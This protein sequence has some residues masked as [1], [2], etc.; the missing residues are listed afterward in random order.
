MEVLINGVKFNALIDT[1]AA[2]SL[3]AGNVWQRWAAAGIKIDPT[4]ITLKTV[5]G[6]DLPT[7]GQVRIDVHPFGLTDLCVTDEITADV[8]LG[9]DTLRRCHVDVLYGEEML[10]VHGKQYPFQETRKFC[11]G[12]TLVAAAFPVETTPDYLSGIEDHPVFEDRLGHCI[13]TEPVRINTEG[14]PIKQRAYRINLLKRRTVDEEIEK[15]LAQGVIRPSQSPWA[16]PITLVPKKDGSTRMCVDYRRINSVTAKDAY[17]VPLIQEIF[18]NLQGSQVFTTLDLR[19]GY[20]QVDVHPDDRQKTAFTCHRGLFEYNRLPFGLTNAPS[21]FQRIMNRILQSHL[22]RRAMVYID[23]VIIYSKTPED[24]ARDVDAVLNT[25]S[26]AGLTFKLKKCHFGQRKVEL[27]GYTVSGD[28]ISQQEDK[29]QAIRGMAAPSD[30]K[31]VQRF[32]GLTGYYR[33]TIPGYAEKAAPLVAL[34]RKGALFQWGQDEQHAFA[35]LKD[36]LTSERIMAHPKSDQAYKLY[37]DASNFAVGAILAQTDADGVE[38][39]VHY[40]SKQLTIGQ[41]KW[42]AIEREAFAIIYAL[43]KLRPYLQGAVFTVYTDHKPLMSLFQCE[44]KNTRVQRWAMLISEFGPK[45]EY[46]SGVN[47]ARADMLSRLPAAIEVAS[48]QTVLHTANSGKEQQRIYPDQWTMAETSDELDQ[49]EAEYVLLG[50]ELY[51]LLLPYQ[52]ASP[53]PRLLVPPSLQPDLLRKG[54]E[55]TG[56]RGQFSLLR[57]LQAFT[58]W[59]GMRNDVQRYIASCPHCAGNRRNPLKTKPCITETPSRPFERIG[60]DL[61]GPFLPSFKGNKYLMNVVDHLT[62]WAESYPIRDKKATTVWQTLL[63]EFFPRHGHP[64]ILITDQGTEFNNHIFDEGL[65]C[66]RID[67]KR[68]TPYHP[69]TNGV[70]ER[71]N[72]TLKDTLRK[73]VN[74]NTAAWEEQLGHALWAYRISDSK[75]RGSSPFF[76]L[77]GREPGRYD[78]T[79]ASDGRHDTMLHARRFAIRMQNEAKERRQEDSRGQALCERQIEVGDM[80]TINAPEPITLA[81]LRRHALRVVETRGKVIGYVQTSGADQTKIYRAHIDRLRVAPADITWDDIQARQNRSRH[82]PDTRTLQAPLALPPLPRATESETSTIRVP[83]HST[84]NTAH[85][86]ATD[87]GIPKVTLTRKH[88]RWRVAQNKR[89]RADSTSSDS[90]A[91]GTP[92]TAPLIRHHTPRA[93]VSQPQKRGADTDSDMMAQEPPLAFQRVNPEEPPCSS[94]AR[95]YSDVLRN[96]VNTS[97]HQQP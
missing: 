50:G 31:A 96:G 67:H 68:T 69:Q 92:K 84:K 88:R 28:G 51:S 20:W 62:G 94:V 32:L 2:I 38:R 72:R 3:L 19:S 18:D 23:D 49:E 34:T 1:G 5:S 10:Q 25:I 37:T 46:R 29:V 14:P 86:R 48:I 44:V 42:S 36:E 63:Q 93:P 11:N 87:S 80:V 41:R 24:H 56:H 78:L 59:P 22:G 64:D 65:R 95:L 60:V 81:H 57:R 26:D 6:E 7:R 54:H 33:Q 71:F 52:G 17:P 39:P 30:L 9:S 47:N 82:G 90:D 12:R 43:K 75:A 76:L 35:A 16:S 83:L 89:R 15:M 53:Y 66:L 27:L 79:G 74:N 45:I 61:T 91:N 21:Q 85:A 77:Y 55:E 73:L 97:L 70:V 40:I 8:I 58:V 4:P 13:C